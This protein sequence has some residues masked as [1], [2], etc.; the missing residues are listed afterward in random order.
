MSRIVDIDIFH[1][2]LPTRREHRWTGLTEPI[3]GYILQRATDSLFVSAT[4]IATPSPGAT[5]YLD[6]GLARNVRYY[7]RIVAVNSAGQSTTWRTVNYRT[8]A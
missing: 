3:G 4:T 1:V 5:T 2:A 7:W 6:A 8:P